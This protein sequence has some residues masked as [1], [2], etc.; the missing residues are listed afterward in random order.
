MNPK[1]RF[2]AQKVTLV[3]SPCY[4][5]WPGHKIGTILSHTN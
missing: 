5:T 4:D 2:I 3:L 1:Q